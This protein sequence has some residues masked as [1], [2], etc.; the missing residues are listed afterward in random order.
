MTHT[1]I[2]WFKNKQISHS[3]LAFEPRLVHCLRQLGFIFAVCYKPQLLAM[4]P[5]RTPSQSLTVTVPSLNW[6]DLPLCY[7]QE[8]GR[9]ARCSEARRIAELATQRRGFLSAAYAFQGL[10]DPAELAFSLPYSHHGSL[11]GPY[12]CPGEVGNGGCFS[13][14]RHSPGLSHTQA[15]LLFRGCSWG[16]GCCWS[17]IFFLSRKNELQGIAFQR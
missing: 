9:P 3:C 10:H 5:W 11:T 2:K 7:S 1:S 13:Y 6:Q 17:L 8:T 14:H 16:L 12:N 4:C 15:D